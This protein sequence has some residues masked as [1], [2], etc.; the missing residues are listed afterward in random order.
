[1]R[2]IDLVHRWLGGLIG[3]V[4]AVLGLS[5]ALLVH[6]DAWVMLPHARDAQAQDV[7]TL[8]GAVE[9]LMADP[10]IRPR[11]IV[12][13][14][15]T[16]GLNRL[17]YAKEEGAYA[18]QAG[19]LVARW[20]SKWERPEI[21]LFDLHH[22]LFSADAGETA[23][24]IAGLCGLGFVVTGVILWWPLRRSYEFR[25]WPER[26]SRFP[27][28][29]HHRDLGVVMAP[30]LVMTLLTGATM[31]FRPVAG[32][33]LGPGTSAA[34]ET[35]LAAPKVPKTRLAARPDWR[36]MIE[37]ARGRFP[38]AEVR[39]LSL[40][41][42]GGGLIGLRLRQPREWLPNGRTMVWFA[43][44]TGRI[45]ATRDAL[46]LPSRVQ[47]YN[48]FYPLHAAKVGGLAYRIVVTLSGVTLTLFG[49]L[50]VWTFWFQRKGR[51]RREPAPA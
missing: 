3:L 41:R 25:L 16:F 36:G 47:A 7:A 27:I 20:D 45:V 49:T 30:L 46:A 18:D 43:A 26:M 17:S 1:M 28:L 22:H 24:G 50:T 14:T 10:E 51:P 29:R 8:A 34:V 35:S 32:V 4:L 19:E 23:A 15:Q 12:F 9:R 5:G 42:Q 33:V 31:V 39:I 40:P 38:D 48:A 21:W 13:A 2:L 44:D 37:A 6:K 11:S